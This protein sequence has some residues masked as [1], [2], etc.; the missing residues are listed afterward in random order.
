MCMLH[1]CSQYAMSTASRSLS[2]SDT[3]FNIFSA[4]GSGPAG[5]EGVIGGAGGLP[6]ALVGVALFPFA[7]GY[8]QA[9]VAL[10][11][12]LRY[13]ETGGAVASWVRVLYGKSAARSAV[14][15][16]VALQCCTA[17]LVS[18]VSLTYVEV[19]AG[20]SKTE[21]GYGTTLCF[22][23]AIIMV[24]G[25]INAV[26]I[27]FTAKAFAWFSA[28]SILAYGT[29]CILSIH[30]MSKSTPGFVASRF[31]ATDPSIH[32]WAE[33]VNLLVYNSCGFDSVASLVNRIEKPEKTLPKAMGLAAGTTM[34]LYGAC[35][36]LPYLATSDGPAAWQP[37]YYVTAARTLGGEWLA[38]WILVSSVLS[39][40]QIFTSSLQTAIYVVQSAAEG[41]MVQARYAR[42]NDTGV[43]TRAL[44]S[45]MAVG[46]LFS[47]VPLMVN[48]AMQS[49]LV[50]LV[51][52]AEIAC[53]LRVSPLDARFSPRT[54]RWRRAMVAPAVVLCVAVMAVQTPWLLLLIGSLLLL[55]A[56]AW[57][58][59]LPP[60]EDGA[61]VKSGWRKL[62]I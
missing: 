47:L 22:S 18:E 44:V 30:K 12:S 40:M 39:N 21:R 17:A 34:L 49:M 25:A 13:P 2:L 19:Y 27:Q 35:I 52:L 36:S 31:R 3:F 38:T 46:V 4:V 59:T 42:A 9:A 56:M 14:M 50:G 58:E 23:A 7:W 41:G 55:T 16:A 43:P 53:F 24:S 11:L 33:L 29:M 6:L 8:V 54:M 48:L 10:D 28:N 57:I 62:C 1:V 15:W 37:G 20:T 60:S 51:L 32:G 45:C 26:S 5:I 61:V